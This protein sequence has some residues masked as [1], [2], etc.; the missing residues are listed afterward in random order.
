[1]QSL[2]SGNDKS[3]CSGSYPVSSYTRKDGIKV[4]GYTKTCYKHRTLKELE[5]NNIKID[6][7]TKEELDLFLAK[8]I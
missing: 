2:Y 4:D 5:E 1:M 8:Y 7:M 6:D 3:K